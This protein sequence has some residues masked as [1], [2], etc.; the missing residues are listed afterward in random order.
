MLDALRLLSRS[1]YSEAISLVLP[2]YRKAPH[3][4]EEFAD[5]DWV[6]PEGSLFPLPAGFT[7]E[8]TVAGLLACVMEGDRQLTKYVAIT[9]GACFRALGAPLAHDD[10]F[11]L[12]R[13]FTMRRDRIKCPPAVT[14]NHLW[15]DFSPE[16]VLQEQCPFVSLAQLAPHLGFEVEVAKGQTRIELR[17]QQAPTR[18]LF[19]EGKKE[20]RAQGAESFSLEHPPFTLQGVLMV[21]AAELAKLLNGQVHWYPQVR[22]MHLIIPKVP[23]KP[24]AQ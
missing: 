24:G 13:A 10:R 9:A 3:R 19:E 16:P 15:V 8:W 18:L 22:F 23:A 6:S 20:V 12:D 5:R 4:R 7:S 11:I 17:R 21:P 14:V 1:S 2:L